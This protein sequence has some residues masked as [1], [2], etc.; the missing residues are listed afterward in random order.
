MDN[1]SHPHL[2]NW[3][4]LRCSLDF[5]ESKMRESQGHYSIMI[6]TWRYSHSKAPLL[7]VLDFA[8]EEGEPALK[9]KT[10]YRYSMDIG[11]KNINMWDVEAELQN[12]LRDPYYKHKWGRRPY[13]NGASRRSFG[14]HGNMDPIEAC[15]AHA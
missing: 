4:N 12:A 15:Q 6:P 9:L 10:G 1:A 14:N 8:Q 3:G 5:I 13:L 2:I 11:I 7:R